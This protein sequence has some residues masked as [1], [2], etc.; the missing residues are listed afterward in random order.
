MRDRISIKFVQTAGI[1]LPR[2]LNSLKY[3]NKSF[4]GTIFAILPSVNS[5]LVSI[6]RNDARRKNYQG[7]IDGYGRLA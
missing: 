6:T 5:L 2:K 3:I 1:G 7:R 4:I